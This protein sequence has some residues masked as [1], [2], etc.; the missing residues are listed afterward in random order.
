MSGWSNLLRSLKKS[1][2][3]PVEAVVKGQIPTWLQGTLFRLIT[4][5]ES[6]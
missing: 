6:K 1:T 3:K 4:L 2:D 5:S